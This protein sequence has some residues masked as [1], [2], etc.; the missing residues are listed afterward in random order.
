MSSYEKWKAAELKKVL[1]AL[2]MDAA[3]V[4][5]SSVMEQR[6]SPHF[7]EGC[8]SWLLYFE[9]GSQL[10]YLDPVDKTQ[11]PIILGKYGPQPLDIWKIEGEL[12]PKYDDLEDGRA[13]FKSLM[14]ARR[15]DEAGRE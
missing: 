7:A 12:R 1:T 6:G 3:S 9:D 10:E 2:E 15:A 13:L 5:N 8:I 4:I 11:K 14:A